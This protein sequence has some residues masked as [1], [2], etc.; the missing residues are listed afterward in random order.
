[1]HELSI[2]LALVEQVEGVVREQGAVGVAKVV[3]KVGALSGVDPEAL[4]E[5]FPLAAEDS[6]VA[7]AELMVEGVEAAVRCRVCGKRSR[8]ESPFICCGECGSGEV[9]IEAGRELYI[10]AIDIDVAEGGV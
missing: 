5:A 1:M 4:R 3:V 10:H 6:V 9:D 2:A 8:P 7:G